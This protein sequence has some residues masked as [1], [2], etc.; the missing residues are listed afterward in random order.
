[1]KKQDKRFIVRKYIIAKSAMEALKKEK[2]HL[3]DD[4][5]IDDDWKK[6]AGDQL[7]SAIGFEV[8]EEPQASGLES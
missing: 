1:M 3:P 4:C 2:R 7:E 5:Y 8:S 6:E